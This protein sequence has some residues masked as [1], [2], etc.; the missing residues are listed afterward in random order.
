M[1]ETIGI[2]EDRVNIKFTTTEGLGEI[3]SGEGIGAMCVVLL[4]EGER[5]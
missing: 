5:S 3:G 4:N 1:A 2:P